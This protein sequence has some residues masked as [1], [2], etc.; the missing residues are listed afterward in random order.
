M[1]GSR[2][3]VSN[4]IRGG[5][6]GREL[7]G[8]YI[9]DMSTGDESEASAASTRTSASGWGGEDPKVR[10]PRVHL[11]V[12]GGRPVWPLA[13][14]QFVTARDRPAFVEQRVECHD[15]LPVLVRSGSAGARLLEELM[16]GYFDEWLLRG[17]R[18]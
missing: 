11:R 12:L 9:A 6:D 16:S 15:F 4:D 8:P 17:C 13:F 2:I 14:H 1:C 7:F 18:R 3:S 10:L 5:V